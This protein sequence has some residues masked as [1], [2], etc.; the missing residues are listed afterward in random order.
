MQA[1]PALVESAVRSATTG[2]P[3]VLC[4]AVYSHQEQQLQVPACCAVL[5]EAVL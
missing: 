4:T 1:E 3:L 2:N 5:F